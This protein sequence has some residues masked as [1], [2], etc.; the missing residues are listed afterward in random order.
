VKASKSPFRLP[1]VT[2]A[3]HTGMRKGEILGLTWERVDFARRVL[4][5]E[6]TKS[7][8]RREV[9]MN[10][11]VYDALDGLPGPKAEGFVFRKRDG[12]AWGNI[13]TAFGD[14]CREAKVDPFRFHGLRHTCAGTGSSP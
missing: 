10:R 9:P 5:L 7:G 1:V 8:R 2:V 11:D 12:R 14:A 6:H 3:L 13:R 4:Q